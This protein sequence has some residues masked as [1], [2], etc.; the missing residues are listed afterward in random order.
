MKILIRKE[1]RSNVTKES[2]KRK[3]FPFMNKH[4]TVNKKI[5]EGNQPNSVL[6]SSLIH[7]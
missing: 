3:G 6:K 2:L 5:T 7:S 4:S 1:S